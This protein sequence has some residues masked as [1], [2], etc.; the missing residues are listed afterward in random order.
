MS[1]TIHTLQEFMLQTK[2]VV[3]IL[4]LG[5]FVGIVAFWRFLNRDDLEKDAD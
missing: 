1:E 3:Y 2:G 5:F 4:A